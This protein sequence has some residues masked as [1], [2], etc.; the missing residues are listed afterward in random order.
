MDGI[1]EGIDCGD[2]LH[3]SGEALRRVDGAAREVEHV[4]STPKIARG[5][6]GSLTR[7]ISR[8]IRLIS[9]NAVT[10]MTTQQRSSASGRAGWDAG[11][12]RADDHDDGPASTALIVPEMLKPAI[13]SS[14]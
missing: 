5:S 2:L 4:L 6:S 1:G 11:D 8:N 7:T 14:L 13:S 3:P 10:T 12:Q 9:A